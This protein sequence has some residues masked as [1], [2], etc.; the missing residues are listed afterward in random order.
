MPIYEYKC[1]KCNKVVEII[2][3]INSD[4]KENCIVCGK[5]MTKL[6]SLSSFHLKGSGWYKDGY[7]NNGK[8][9]K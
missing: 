3:N 2:K 4:T 7:T 5:E 8:D 9:A 6:I 1:K